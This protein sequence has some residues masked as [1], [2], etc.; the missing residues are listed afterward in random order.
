LKVKCSENFEQLK[1][2]KYISKSNCAV[3][4]GSDDKD[5]NTP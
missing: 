3:D 4:G 2:K 5:D 1:L